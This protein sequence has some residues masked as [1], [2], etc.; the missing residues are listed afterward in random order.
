MLPA[1]LLSSRWHDEGDKTCLTFWWSTPQGPV[2]TRIEHPCVCFIRQED[3]QKAERIVQA[4]GWPVDIRPVALK[5]FSGD[6]AAACYLPSDYLYRWR[7]ALR[8][9]GADVWEL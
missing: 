5:L 6:A 4:L 8:D 1:F 7:N 2:R 3:T 9:Q